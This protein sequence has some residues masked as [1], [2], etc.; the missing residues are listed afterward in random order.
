MK[1]RR[2]ECR[3]STFNLRSDTPCTSSDVFDKVQTR[4]LQKAAF[5]PAFYLSMASSL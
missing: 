2:K 3:K 1:E 5:E 4:T